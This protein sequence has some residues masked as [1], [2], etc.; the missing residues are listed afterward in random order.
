[1]G[2]IIKHHVNICMKGIDYR[3]I[4][5]GKYKMAKLVKFMPGFE[6]SCLF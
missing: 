5:W 3:L 1:M 2:L 6:I 4:M